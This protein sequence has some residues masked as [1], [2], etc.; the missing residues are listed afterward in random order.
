[1][2]YKENK[3]IDYIIK[4]LVIEK[5]GFYKL[6][7]RRYNIFEIFY[8]HVILVKSKNRKILYIEN[9]RNIRFL[10]LIG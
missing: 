8:E 6:F 2:P 4:H 5:P 7:E 9:N 1:M 10:I 3:T